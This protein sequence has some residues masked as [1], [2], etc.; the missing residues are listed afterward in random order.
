M[1]LVYMN[2][3]LFSRYGEQNGNIHSII[4]NDILGW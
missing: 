4:S 3:E 2:N 1:T